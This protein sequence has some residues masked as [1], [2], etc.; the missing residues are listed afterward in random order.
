MERFDPD[1]VY[2]A[3]VHDGEQG[4][5][6]LKRF[7][8]P[9]VDRPVSFLPEAPGS[10]LI[11]LS[12]HPSPQVEILFGG[13]H[14]E[15][16]PERLSAEEFIGV[17]GFKAHGKRLSSYEIARASFIEPQLPDSEETPGD[18]E[19]DEEKEENGSQRNLFD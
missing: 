16:E 3:I 19:S 6:Y 2:C 13:R 15:R 14:E 11:A 17:K 12:G 1:K 9:E 4:F 18:E 7:T 5:H 8:T 10:Q